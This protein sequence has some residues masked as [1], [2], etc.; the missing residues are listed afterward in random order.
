MIAPQMLERRNTHRSWKV[1]FTLEVCKPKSCEWLEFY[2]FDARRDCSG[3]VVGYSY[4][5]K[6]QSTYARLHTR[7]PSEALNL[8]THC[9]QLSTYRRTLRHL[10]TRRKMRRSMRRSTCR[11]EEPETSPCGRQRT[12]AQDEPNTSTSQSRATSLQYLC[13][14]PTHQGGQRRSL[15]IHR[16]DCGQA[17]PGLSRR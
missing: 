4:F 10:S 8:I 13:S 5:T 6:R 1:F 15:E 16:V 17:V 2:S 3:R 7:N 12:T 14:L 11:K 9:P